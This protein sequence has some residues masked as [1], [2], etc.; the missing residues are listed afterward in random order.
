MKIHSSAWTKLPAFPQKPRLKRKQAATDL[1]AK[2]V[3]MPSIGLPTVSNQTPGASARCAIKFS[4][5]LTSAVIAKCRTL[6]FSVTTAPH[7][8]VV[9]ATSQHADPTSSADRYTSWWTFILRRYCP[10]PYNGARNAVSIFHP[11]IP[12]TV[13]PSDFLGIAAQLRGI[14][15]RNPTNMFAFLSCYIDKVLT[16]LIQPPLPRALPPAEPILNSLGVIDDYLESKHGED[17]EIADFR[18]DADATVHSIC[19][20][21]TG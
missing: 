9:C 5:Q 14:Y 2:S 15:T 1:A 8:A 3:N 11:R 4:T 18:F 21:S 6:G 20:D 7:A 17:I 19:M 16:I 13:D 12:V 10:P